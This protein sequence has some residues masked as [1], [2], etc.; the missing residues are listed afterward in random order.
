MR[1]CQC[2]YDDDIGVE[3]YLPRT[4]GHMD[5]INA[6]CITPD[7]ESVV[8]VSSDRT[9][10]VWDKDGEE[11]RC[12]SENFGVITDVDVSPDGESIVTSFWGKKTAVWDRDSG[13]MEATMVDSGVVLSCIFHP[14]GKRILTGCQDTTIKVHERR[15]LPHRLFNRTLMRCYGPRITGVHQ[16]RQMFPLGSW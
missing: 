12:I 16:C 6:V 14:D 5:D 7:G 2:R 9:I 11:G 10:K 8:S 3:E 15:T 4:P 13:E 1:L